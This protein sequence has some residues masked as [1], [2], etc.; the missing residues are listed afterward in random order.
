MYR[1][2]FYFFNIVF[3]E[4]D[5]TRID[6]GNERMNTEILHSMLF[7]PKHGTMSV[8]RNASA[9]LSENSFIY[10]LPDWARIMKFPLYHNKTVRNDF[11]RSN[12]NRFSRAEALVI[13][14]VCRVDLRRGR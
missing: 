5:G 8:V 9:P 6:P 7:Y 4:K 3:V 12:S 11:T 14:D 2:V 13:R 10:Y 1:I